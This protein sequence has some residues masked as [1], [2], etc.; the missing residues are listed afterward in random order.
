EAGQKIAVDLFAGAEAAD[1]VQVGDGL[2]RAEGVPVL[3]EERQGIAG[4]SALE[5]QDDFAEAAAAQG[6]RGEKGEVMVAGWFGES[7]G[8]A[9]GER[10]ELEDVILVV[11]LQFE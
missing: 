5:M 7:E 4:G 1:G 9:R 10:G 6:G 2:E 3:G 11:G 8:G